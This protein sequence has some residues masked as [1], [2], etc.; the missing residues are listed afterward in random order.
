VRKLFPD[1]KT[2]VFRFIEL[3]ERP[4]TPW[5]A[6]QIGTEFFYQRG[7]TDLVAVSVQGKVIAF[8]AKLKKWKIALQQAYRNKC[9]A[10][11]SYVLLPKEEAKNASRY[12]N[13]FKRRDVGLCYMSDEEVNILFHAKC[14]EPLQPWLRHKALLFVNKEEG[15]YGEESGISSKSNL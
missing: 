1:E 14:T 4:T 9:F 13:E 11:I 3:I 2:M 7:R 12:S 8:E 10:D 6:L 15:T 5:G